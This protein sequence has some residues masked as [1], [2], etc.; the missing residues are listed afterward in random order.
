MLLGA[1][2]GLYLLTGL[3]LMLCLFIA[4]FVTLVVLGFEKHGFRPM[5][6]IIGCFVLTIGL[7]YIVELFIAPPN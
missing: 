4:G 2:L 3:S 5:E 6:L 1:A 7:C